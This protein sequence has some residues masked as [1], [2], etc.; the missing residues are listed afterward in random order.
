MTK[1]SSRKMFGTRFSARHENEK[2]VFLIL[3]IE[4]CILIILIDILVLGVKL[5][6][7]FVANPFKSGI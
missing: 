7:F 3:R 2:G 5:F 6:Y 4:T 1:K